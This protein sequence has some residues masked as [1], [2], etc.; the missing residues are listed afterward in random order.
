MIHYLTHQGR[1]TCLTTVKIG[2]PVNLRRRPPIMKC[3]K[4][5]CS[6]IVFTLEIYIAISNT[7]V[8]YSMF[9]FDFNKLKIFTKIN[10]PG[11]YIWKLISTAVLKI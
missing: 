10:K 2:V 3:Q 11:Y 4:R 8:D 6:R 9:E 7:T 5:I 1:F